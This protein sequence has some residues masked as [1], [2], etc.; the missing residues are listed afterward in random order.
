MKRG[1][2]GGEVFGGIRFLVLIITLSI[3]LTAC[4]GGGDGNQTSTLSITKA[5]TGGGTVTSSPA[6]INCGTDCSESYSNNQAVTLTATED[7][8]SIFTG[9]GGDCSGTSA[10]A[11]LTMEYK[12][13]QRLFKR[14]YELYGVPY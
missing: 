3:L 1:W 4:G 11:S 13:G 9:W 14:K 10:S 7:T 6:G 5:G 12:Q 8:G 2:E